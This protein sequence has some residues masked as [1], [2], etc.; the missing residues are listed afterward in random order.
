METG[1]VKWFNRTKGYGFIEPDNGGKDI[2]VH[3]SEVEKIGIYDLK[4]EQKVSFDIENNRGREAAAN[5]KLI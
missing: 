1:K 5:L 3:I 4:E 2:F